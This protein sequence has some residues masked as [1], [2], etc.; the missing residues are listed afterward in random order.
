MLVAAPGYPMWF[1]EPH[2]E[3][4]LS[5]ELEVRFEHCRM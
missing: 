3:S 5:T 2:K 4:A 1:P